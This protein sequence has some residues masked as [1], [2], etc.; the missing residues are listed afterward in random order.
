MSQER[1]VI[2]WDGNAEPARWNVE[3]LQED[4][5]GREMVILSSS[6]PDFPVNV[7]EFGPM[8]EDALIDSIKASFPGAHINIRF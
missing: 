7:E 2:E 8:E 6:S 3:M 4:R 5:Q 1:I